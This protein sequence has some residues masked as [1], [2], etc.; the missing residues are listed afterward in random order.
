[1]SHRAG[2]AAFVY[3][4]L[5][6]C[7]AGL[8]AKWSLLGF[9]YTIEDTRGKVLANLNWEVPEQL[10]L[11]QVLCPG[12]RV[13]NLGGNIG[14]SCITIAK[15]LGATGS[16]TCVEPSPLVL[17]RLKK[18]RGAGAVQF[19]IHEGIVGPSARACDDIELYVT[20]VTASRPGLGL[21]GHAYTQSQSSPSVTKVQCVGLE[22]VAG[23]EHFSVLFADCE[24]CLSPALLDA[25][26]Q[27][28]VRTV[29]FEYDSARYKA[30]ESQLETHGFGQ[31]ISGHVRVWQS[32]SAR[33]RRSK[34][35][36]ATLYYADLLLYWGGGFVWLLS[37]IL[38][39]ALGYFFCSVV[40]SGLEARHT[41]PMK[42]L[43]NY[44]YKG[45]V[46]S[47]GLLV[48]TAC[49]LWRVAG[50]GPF[51]LGS[52][53]LV[54]FCMY[55]EA[56]RVNRRM[57]IV[58]GLLL[59]LALV[60]CLL[61]V[62]LCLARQMWRVLRGR[63]TWACKDWDGYIIP[64][65][66]FITVGLA[67]ACVSVFDCCCVVASAS[68]RKTVDIVERPSTADYEVVSRPTETGEV[69]RVFGAEMIGS[70]CVD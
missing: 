30:V 49:S 6:F 24:G 31:V 55:R 14:G 23:A 50:V 40:E 54:A 59:P 21:S 27:Q 17:P 2:V 64:S 37:R 52:A 33:C 20:N 43:A 51:W 45:I 11:W 35:M 57:A 62:N 9:S 60:V 46:S 26:V 39:L 66:R 58:G 19:K 15:I 8:S 68:M 67:A 4:A 12:D 47:L 36:V 7:T 10:A 3:V 41:W 69:R 65:P 38:V 5:L 28:G 22:Q 29:V 34:Q 42:G 44:D 13:L 18:N 56:W 48:Q 63:R 1:M 53:L 61:P 25:A 70:P 32:P 16:I